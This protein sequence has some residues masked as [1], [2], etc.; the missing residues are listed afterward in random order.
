[1]AKLEKHKLRIPIK[2]CSGS[3]MTMIC[4]KDIQSM[5]YIRNEN[6]K[7]YIITS[8][9]D[10]NNIIFTHNFTYTT[11]KFYYDI[12]NKIGKAREQNPNDSIVIIG[13][14]VYLLSEIEF[15]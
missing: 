5:Y 12:V 8:G 13:T 10:E 2:D 3:N 6:K 7:F 9:H 11:A 4:V 14:S 15:V 1:M